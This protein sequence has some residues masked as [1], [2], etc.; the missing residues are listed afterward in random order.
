MTKQCKYYLKLCR[1]LSENE[2]KYNSKDHFIRNVHKLK[3]GIEVRKYCSEAESVFD[4][5][6][7]NGYLKRAQFGYDLTQK[8]L[9]PKRMIWE[10]IRAFLIK[11]IV[12]PII[13]SAITSI[14]TVYIGSRL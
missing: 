8:G 6:L 10:D 1:K 11:S 9:H 3:G 13:V 14:I 7:D 2:F 5:L 4:C 12:V